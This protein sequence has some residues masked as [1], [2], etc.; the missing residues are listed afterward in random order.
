MKHNILET[1]YSYKRSL[2][3][4]ISNYNEVNFELNK[5]C[6]EI[7]L[8]VL[9]YIDKFNKKKLYNKEDF[10][11]LIKAIENLEKQCSLDLEKMYNILTKSQLTLTLKL[12]NTKFYL[13]SKKHKLI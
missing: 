8:Y 2:Y 6:D 5:K 12:Q 7:Y 13:Q 1:I 10:N 3:K 9:N 11:N 4:D